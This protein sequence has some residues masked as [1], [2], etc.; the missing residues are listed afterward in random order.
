MTDIKLPPLRPPALFNRR[1]TSEDMRTYATEAVKL[2]MPNWQPM[3]GPQRQPDLLV[4]LLFLAGM[5]AGAAVAIALL[6]LFYFA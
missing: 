5:M 6:A 2:N 3:T 4:P 1:Y